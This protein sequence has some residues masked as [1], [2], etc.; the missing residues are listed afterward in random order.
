MIINLERGT[1]MIFRSFCLLLI[2]ATVCFAQ[3]GAE[4]MVKSAHEKAQSMHS[5]VR[6]EAIDWKPFLF[7][8][9]MAVISGDPGKEGSPFVLRIKQPDGMKIPPHWHPVDENLTVLK[10]TILIGMGETFD[11][12]KL[13]ELSVGAFIVLPKI[14]PH[15]ATTKGETIVQLHG[16]GPF[17]VTFVNPNDDP[18]K[19]SSTQ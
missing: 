8:A 18:R 9:E 17:Q 5:A 13:E 11:A 10:G 2:C 6:P 1:L 19:K 12:A 4:K 16:V 7:G 14:K 15:F 3:T